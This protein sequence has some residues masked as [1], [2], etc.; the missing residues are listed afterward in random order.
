MLEWRPCFIEEN[1]IQVLQADKTTEYE[2]LGRVIFRKYDTHAQFT[3][4][5]T[6]LQNGVAG[7]RMITITERRVYHAT[8]LINITPSSKPNGRTPYE[9]WYNRIPSM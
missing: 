6:L 4:A 1:D 5:Y 9:L 3:N 8:T 7:R 2:K